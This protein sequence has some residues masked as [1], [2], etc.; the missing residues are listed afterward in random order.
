[1]KKLPLAIII[2]FLAL[3]IGKSQES[4]FSLNYTFGIPL[5]K[6]NDF[7]DNTSFRG[8]SFEDRHFVTPMLTI[9]ANFGWQVYNKKL[10]NYTEEFDNGMLY[11]NQYRYINVYP[12]LATTHY[13]LWPE[14]YLRPY[15]G[16]GIGVY[17]I[18]QI[19][20]MGLYSSTIRSWNFGLA[21][22]VGVLYDLSPEI[23]LLAGITYNHAFKSGDSN[24]YSAL[25][26]KIGVVWV[27][28]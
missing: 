9:G 26:F 6:T 23:N 3:N 25:N 11:G 21:P 2:V 27:R 24:G 10:L 4:F 18:N 22:E 14:K 12:I 8:I 15:F 19:T 20:E 16:S 1:M 13:H 17:N 5:G 28:L 7:N